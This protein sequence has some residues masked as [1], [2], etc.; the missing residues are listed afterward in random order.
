MFLSKL[1]VTAL[2]TA[3]AAALNRG[4]IRLGA[5]RRQITA[6]G[7][8]CR[9]NGRQRQQAPEKGADRVPHLKYEILLSRDGGEAQSVAVVETYANGLPMT[10]RTADAVITIQPHRVGPADGLTVLTKWSSDLPLLDQLI[11]R[12]EGFKQSSPN[13]TD[14]QIAETLA[15]ELVAIA[16]ANEAGR[17]PK[18]SPHRSDQKRVRRLRQ[19]KPSGRVSG[20]TD[21]QSG[22]G[23]PAIVGPSARE[24]CHAR[25]DRSRRYDQ[26]PG[27]QAGGIQ[28]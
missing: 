28:G 1:R 27:T 22:G 20:R 2:A 11:W 8:E 12:L 7:F 4:S 26:P 25:R 17:G 21:C 23:R 3:F 9:Q 5:R 15:G 6:V 13:L 14:Q 10:T 16:E 24:G 19:E 18:R